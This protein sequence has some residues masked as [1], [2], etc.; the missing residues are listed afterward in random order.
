MGVRTQAELRTAGTARGRTGRKAQWE[1]VV[2]G[3]AAVASRGVGR[4]RPGSRMARVRTGRPHRWGGRRW[5]HCNPP[6]EEEQPSGG[7]VP[8]FKQGE[9]GATP[10]ESAPG[11]GRSVGLHDLCKEGR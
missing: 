9:T 8:K 5:L 6:A 7:A 3:A 10:A 1:W 2:R 11:P 4:N